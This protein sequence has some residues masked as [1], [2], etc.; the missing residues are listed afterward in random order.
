ML[1]AWQWL[2][3]YFFYTK[4]V[5]DKPNLTVSIL[6]AIC[7]LNYHAILIKIKANCIYETKKHFLVLKKW[8]TFKILH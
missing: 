3:F 5:I 7:R 8:Q 6:N 1:F 2:N 4:Y